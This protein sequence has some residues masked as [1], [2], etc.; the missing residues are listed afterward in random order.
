MVLAGLACCLKRQGNDAVATSAEPPPPKF[1]DLF[2]L[3]AE[4]KEEAPEETEANREVRQ[5]EEEVPD[6]GRVVLR[7]AKKG[8]SAEA[9]AKE[10]E[11]KEAKGGSTGGSTG[12][13]FEYW[14]DRAVSY[15]NLE[16][17]ARKWVLV[18]KEPEAY[19][20]RRRVL[21]AR[22]ASTPDPVFANLKTYNAAAQVQVKVEQANV[23]RWRG[24][25]REVP[26]PEP[27]QPERPTLRYGDFKKNV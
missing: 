14:A 20:V 11:A 1:S 23:Y 15:P 3:G 18:Y 4:E 12:G 8:A 24:K 26:R 2:P 17:L 5:V 9:E 19:V 16:A 7:R 27:P 25:V 22:P 10:A 21:E 6:S 13:E